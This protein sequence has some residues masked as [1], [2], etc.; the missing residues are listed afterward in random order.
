MSEGFT[1]PDRRD[2]EDTHHGAAML[3]VLQ[4]LHET[5]TR[6]SVLAF[7]RHSA[8]HYGQAENDLDNPLSDHGRALCHRFGAALPRWS[9][10]ATL[11][12]TSG[13]CIETAELISASHAHPRAAPNRTLDALAA[14]YV[15]DL[16]KVGGMMKHLSPEETLRR[17]FAGEVPAAVMMPP[18]DAAHR[19]M[20]TIVDTLRAAPADALTLCVSHD[21]TLYLLRHVV[22]ELLYGD[23]PPAEYLDGFAFWLD[24]DELAVSSTL[25]GMRRVAAWPRR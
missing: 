18:L 14:F 10:Y 13:R 9:G 12:S 23:H 19:V 11:S 16:R 15:R 24:G 4:S 6:P 21:W 22:L 3:S 7:I 2:L 8:R 1:T 17:W 20:A 5:A 25:C